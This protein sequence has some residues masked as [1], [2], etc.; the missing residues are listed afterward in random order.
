MD[1]QQE[2]VSLFLIVPK[3]ISSSR[4]FREVKR[5]EKT[6]KLSIKVSNTRI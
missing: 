4:D 5:E 2:E 1:Y 6:C 3:A